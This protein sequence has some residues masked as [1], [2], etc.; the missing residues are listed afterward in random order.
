M[1]KE[2]IKSWLDD[3]DSMIDYEGDV[4][5]KEEDDRDA[6]KY[7]RNSIEVIDEFRKWLDNTRI[8]IDDLGNHTVC[9]TVLKDVL[10]YIEEKK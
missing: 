7:L 8:R 3:I 10:N 1:N 9:V 6:V 2:D 5:W 4:I